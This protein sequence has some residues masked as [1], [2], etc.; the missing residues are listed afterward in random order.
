MSAEL[1]ISGNI[2]PCSFTL[3]KGSQGNASVQHA[4]DQLKE[5]LEDCSPFQHR[6][7]NSISFKGLQQQLDGVTDAAQLNEVVLSIEA[8]VL[9][10]GSGPRGMPKTR[11]FS[12]T[13]FAKLLY[14]WP[15]SYVLI[16]MHQRACSNRS[17]GW[18][19]LLS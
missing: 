17:T 16:L 10:L 8:A 6:I 11:T 1:H 12:V 15:K 7:P 18:Q 2:L 13:S 5:L 14:V 19:T 3:K 4:V 9:H